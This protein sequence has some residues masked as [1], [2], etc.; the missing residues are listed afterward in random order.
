[1]RSWGS[2]GEHQD[3]MDGR[4]VVSLEGQTAAGMPSGIPILVC[5]SLAC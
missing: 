5:P 4:E 1:M 2:H 3:S